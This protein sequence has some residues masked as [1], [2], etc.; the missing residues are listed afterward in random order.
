MKLTYR[1]NRE[2]IHILETV[3]GFDTEFEIKILEDGPLV[4]GIKEIEKVFEDNRVYTDVMFYVYEHH[5]YKVIVRKDYYDQFI[6]ALMQYRLLL[7]VEW[8]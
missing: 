4:A 3:N 8:V 7:S 6:L 5:H 1:F 2:Q